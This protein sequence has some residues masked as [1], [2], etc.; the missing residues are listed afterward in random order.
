MPGVRL[1]HRLRRRRQPPRAGARRLRG[2]CDPAEVNARAFADQARRIAELGGEEAVRKAG[3]YPCTPAP[4]E[5]GRIS[6]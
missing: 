5:A 4:G 1:D 3:D 2:I 6:S